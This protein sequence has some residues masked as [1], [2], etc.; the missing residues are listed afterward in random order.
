MAAGVALPVVK[1]RVVLIRAV[2][3]PS[4]SSPESTTAIVTPAPVRDVV[5]PGDAGLSD[6]AAAAHVP[7]PEPVVNQFIVTEAA[8]VA[9]APTPHTSPPEVPVLPVQRCDCAAPLV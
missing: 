5:S 8:P 9:M 4:C 3:P 7:A 2:E 6:T 1:S